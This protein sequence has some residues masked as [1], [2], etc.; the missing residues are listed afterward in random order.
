[1]FGGTLYNSSGATHIGFADTVDSLSAIEKTVFIDKICSFGELSKALDADF[2]GYEKLHAY[3]VHK[4]PKYGTDDPLAIKN[5]RN[6]IRFLYDTYQ[7]YTNHRGGKY[8]PAF[9]TTTN[10]AGQGKLAGA[11][12]NGRKAYTAFTS[13]ITP[14]SQAAKELTTC[15]RAV[16]S[17][18]SLCIPGGEALNLKF[19]LIKDSGD[20][21][22]FGAAV[23]AYFRM[24]GM[25]VQ[26]NIMSYETLMDAKKNPDKYPELLVRVSGYSAYFRDLNETMKDEIITRTE[27]DIGTG[28]ANPL[29]ATERDP[30]KP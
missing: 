7:G 22:K 30:G 1:V 23:E 25:H 5:S 24:G 19:P 28:N 27:Y 26:F 21:E 14:V 6:L 20:I 18:D 17:L 12:P 8:R 4:A 11:L 3:L 2:K 13:G 9:W 15:L 16:G 29:P 10:H